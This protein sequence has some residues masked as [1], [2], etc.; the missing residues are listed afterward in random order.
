MLSRGQQSLKTLGNFKKKQKNQRISDYASPASYFLAFSEIPWFFWFFL[1]FPRVFQRFAFSFS[2]SL[3]T[4]G[5]FKKKQKKQRISDYASPASYFLAFSEI[6]W[7]FWFFLKFP[8]VFQRFA[9]SFSSTKDFL[10]K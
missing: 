4:L 10:Y 6:P 7:F 8:R 3:K 1:K 2:S 9:F 5:N